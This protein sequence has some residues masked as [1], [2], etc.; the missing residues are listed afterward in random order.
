MCNAYVASIEFRDGSFYNSGMKHPQ[1]HHLMFTNFSSLCIHTT[2]RSQLNLGI[3]HSVS[4]MAMN[5][6]GDQS[7]FVH[8]R[9]QRHIQFGDACS[10]QGCWYN[11]TQIFLVVHKPE[12]LLEY[13]ISII[14]K[15]RLYL[16]LYTL[17]HCLALYLT[18]LWLH[19]HFKESVIIFN[20][21]VDI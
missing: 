20:C 10:T 2:T 3:V 16:A 4:N 21:S 6:Q 12:L 5:L 13:I 9:W 7:E 14:E 19:D 11:Q 15:Y 18:T 17:L 8:K 1:D